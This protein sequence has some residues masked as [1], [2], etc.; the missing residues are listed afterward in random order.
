M[1]IEVFDPKGKKIEEISLSKKVFGQKV[2]EDLLAQYVHVYRTN[3]R[4]GTVATKTRAQVSGGGKKPWRQK[5]T[6]RARHGSIRSPIW[7]HG[8]V[9]HGPKPRPWSLSM[10]K[11]MRKAAMVNALSAKYQS[12]NLKIVDQISF[13]K[14]STKKMNEIVKKL[15]LE[16]NTLI[17]LNNS[18]ENFVKSVRN[19][20]RLRSASSQNL[21]VYDVLNCSNLVLLKD[22]L[23]SLEEKYQ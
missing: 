19:L 10:P 3:K 22:S 23:K 18:D 7:V 12:G 6:G 14:P 17:V 4:Q 1:K 13:D 9:A 20:P 2:N 21:N 8:G 15:G 16:G 5:G 11:K